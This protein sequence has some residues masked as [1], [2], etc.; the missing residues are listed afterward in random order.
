MKEKKRYHYLEHLLGIEQ[1]A[2]AVAAAAANSNWPKLWMVA[3]KEKE[4]EKNT[5]K[6]IV[7]NF[8]RT[9]SVPQT[10]LSAF[11]LRT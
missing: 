5:L 1:Y 8:L 11:L 2:A 3:K 9:T 4:E 6:V 10:K 7:N